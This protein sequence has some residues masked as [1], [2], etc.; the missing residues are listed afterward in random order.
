MCFLGDE[1]N[2]DR[3]RSLLAVVNQAMDVLLAGRRRHLSA[4]AMVTFNQSTFRRTR[5]KPCLMGWFPAR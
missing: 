2:C 3:G 1:E 4:V 5:S